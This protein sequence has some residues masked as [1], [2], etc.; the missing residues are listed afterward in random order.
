MATIDA[1]KHGIAHIVGGTASQ[2]RNSLHAGGPLAVAA[3]HFV[4]VV[5]AKDLPP[6]DAAGNVAVTMRMFEFLLLECF[7]PGPDFPDHQAWVAEVTAFSQM[8]A[9][10]DD[11]SVSWV[12]CS[13]EQLQARFL[14]RAQQ[15][16]DVRRILPR[17]KLTVYTAAAD[18][19]DTAW[20]YVSAKLLMAR[21]PTCSNLMQFRQ[22]IGY[23]YTLADRQSNNFTE[24]WDYIKTSDGLDGVDDVG[25]AAGASKVA[26]WFRRTRQ[27]SNLYMF[28]DVDECAVEVSR[29]QEDAEGRFLPLFEGRYRDAY[30]SIAVVLKKSC[31][32]GAAAQFTTS[33]AIQLQN[34]QKLDG[35][36]ASDCER[37]H[38]E[39]SAVPG[40]WQ[41]ARRRKH[42]AGA[43]RRRVH[44]G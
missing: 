43:R 2:K 15:L 10:L 11:G 31:D 36:I 3:G 33:M 21:D 4:A 20:D 17:A 27:D 19:T 29:R 14:V 37:L 32:G 5:L 7:K 34:T 42:D 41:A 38:H 44:Q 6:P 30:P 25:R 22:T 40:H 26:T 18:F 1:T 9:D 16:P 28:F 8:L 12:P 24:I 39:R 23:A 13:V 35:P